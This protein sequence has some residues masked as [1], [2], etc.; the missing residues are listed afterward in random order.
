MSEREGLEGLLTMLGV[1]SS[2]DAAR[3]RSMNDEYSRLR[4]EL[5]HGTTVHGK[6][7]QL[8]PGEICTLFIMLCG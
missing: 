7:A 3:L 2:R 4:R 8:W 5:D 1:L 6:R